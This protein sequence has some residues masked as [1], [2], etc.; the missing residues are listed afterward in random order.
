MP[1]K[2]GSLPF[3]AQIAFFRKKLALPTRG[4]TD[5]WQGNHDHAF[6]ISGATK[7]ALL[8]DM[9]AA[10]QKAME[11][12]TTLAEFRK[13][14][15]KSVAKHGWAYKGSRGWRTR[16]IYETNL[17]TSH[18]AG[19]H[20]QLQKLDYW[21]Y[22]H[23]IGA[24]NP[25]EQH[26][27]WHGLVLAKDDAF[28]HTHYP[29]NGWGCRCYVTGMSKIRMKQKGLSLGQSP[30]ISMKKLVVG[31]NSPNP[32]TVDV[33]EGIS[34]G[35]AYAPGR[36]AWMQNHVPTLQGEVPHGFDKLI[37]AVSARD[38]LPAPRPFAKNKLLAKM[39]KGQEEQYANQFLQAFDASVGKSSL[40]IDKAGEG[41]VMS[42]SMF[43]DVNGSWKIGKRGRD[44]YLPMLAETIKQ[45]DEIWTWMEWHKNNNKAFVS[46]AYI[47]RFQ[48]DGKDYTSLL[49][50]ERSGKTW[51]GITAHA[52]TSAKDL[53]AKIERNR[54]G[55][56][57]YKRDNN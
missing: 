34:P 26:L 14:F 38:L 29:P 12:G 55:V 39:Q 10:V 28:W 42:E 7:M 37:P 43:K 30:K 23:S 8:E 54:R 3:D 27:V 18:A 21:Q 48:I 46:R 15:D 49:V 35:F 5:I 24:N 57:L 13:D 17:R 51:Q 33:P 56:R 52:S 53:N 20:D 2:Y 16:V 36:S 50:L 41:I 19:R 6:V 4:W 47:S 22:H 45:P 31:K 32:R 11:Q 25:R 40:F 9:Q 44:V 1:V